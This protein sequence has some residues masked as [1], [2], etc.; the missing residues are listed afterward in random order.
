MCR[1]NEMIES[2]M[3]HNPLSRAAQHL[4]VTPLR[5]SDEVVHGLVLGAGMKRNHSGGHG[6]HQ[7]GAVTAEPRMS[8]RLKSMSQVHQ[9][10]LEFHVCIH[11]T[12]SSEK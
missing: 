6:Q 5:F 8:I 10:A 3:W 11:Q 12:P 1:R 9:V 2:G 7:A 4:R